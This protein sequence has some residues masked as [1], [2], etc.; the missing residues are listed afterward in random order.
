MRRHLGSYQLDDKDRKILCMLQADAS[1]SL[2]DMANS[3][4]L[5]KMAISNRIRKIKQAGF[6]EGSYYKLNAEKMD[7]D[8][9]VISM[10]TCD[11]KGEELEEIGKSI[12]SFKGVMSVYIL[13]GSYDIILIA[14][15]KDKTSAKRLIYNVSKIP[16]VRSTMTMVPHTVV[17]ESL[18]IDTLSG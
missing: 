5:T 8:Y 13:F 17:K 16:G 18:I 9:V 12:A 10:V 7:Q 1:T 11:P 6:I 4:G 2:S 14:R 3:I 15:R